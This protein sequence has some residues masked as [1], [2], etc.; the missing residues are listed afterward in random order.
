MRKIKIDLYP[1]DNC[2]QKLTHRKTTKIVNRKIR[3]DGKYGFCS[4]LCY[5]IFFKDKSLYGAGIGIQEYICAYCQNIFKRHAYKKRGHDSK[6]DF[7]SLHC[8]SI[9][10]NKIVGFK[11]A[12]C[13]SC[14]TLIEIGLHQH[15]ANA[16]CPSCGLKNNIKIY[17]SKCKFRF[18]LKDH[19]EDF[20]MALIEKH[21]W[22]NRNNNKNGVSKDHLYSI[23]DGYKNKVD[24]RL[25]S[26]PANCQLVLQ[27]QNRE[28][29]YNSNITLDDLKKRIRAWNNQH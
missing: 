24:F 5:R 12:K 29:Y 8:S 7:C 3:G 4:N 17:R 1:C 26:H 19:A 28:K 23:R 10:N 2:G 25:L 20:N 15:Y 6:N 14:G 11:K 21:G 16:M 9:F 13:I 22:Y 18:N 27:S